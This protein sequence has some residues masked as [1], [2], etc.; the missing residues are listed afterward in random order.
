[1]RTINSAFVMRQED[2][3]GSLKVGK[4]ADF[5]IIDRDIFEKE[6]QNNWNAIKKTKVL[7]TQLEGQEI[8]TKSGYTF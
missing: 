5:I 2:R 4:D 8:W 7:H 6:R 3:T 1:M